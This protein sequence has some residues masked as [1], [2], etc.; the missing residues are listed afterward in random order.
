MEKINEKDLNFLDFILPIISKNIIASYYID[1][2]AEEYK[3][4]TGIEFTIDDLRIFI[5]EYDNKYIIKFGSGLK[6]KMSIEM[7]RIIDQYGSL[8]KYIEEQNNLEL[9]ELEESNELN[10]L[11][12]KNIELQNKNLQ[13]QNKQMKRYV[14]YSIISFILGA[15]VTNLKDILILL[16]L[17]N[18][19]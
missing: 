12:I 7:K 3:S 6:V 16:N 19:E 4:E 2:L 1:Y 14:I 5:D 9:K 15:V 8:S 17:M 18:Q 13:L 11:Q 10:K